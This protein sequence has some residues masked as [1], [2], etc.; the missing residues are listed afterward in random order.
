MLKIY[1]RANS[2]NVRKVLWICDEIGLPFDREDWGRGYRPTSEDVYK[3]IN[4]FEV[5]P[6]IDDDG[7]TLRESNTIVRYLATK[8][9]REDLYP[10]DLH[11]RFRCEAWMDWASQDLYTDVRPI[12]MALIFNVPEYQV[13]EIQKKAIAGWSRVM[14]MLEQYLSDGDPYLLGQTFTIAD[15]PTGLVVNRWYTLD[16]PK[17]ELPAVQAYYDRL[18]ARPPFRAHGRNG[19]P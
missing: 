3:R 9:G 14:E 17:P 8:H 12:V 11:G 13:P 15:I 1:G 4:P 2:I 7:F 18:S 10:S 6:A 5:V 19:L 16:F